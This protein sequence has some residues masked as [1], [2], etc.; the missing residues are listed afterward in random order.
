MKRRDALVS[1][2]LLPLT[3]S[4]WKNAE[5][6]SSSIPDNLK[7]L[8]QGD[9]I[10]DA[11]RN[12][13]RYYANDGYGMGNGYVSFTVKHLLGTQPQKNIKCYNRG[14]S[15]HKVHQ[16]A[17]RWDDDCLNL[18]P[19]VM[20]ILIGVNDY[21]HTLTHGYTGDINRYKNDYGV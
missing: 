20:S 1:T 18:K 17:D 12:R 3:I 2:G 7:I 6:L 9:S 14:I 15:G 11:G 19:D 8:F 5:I 4:L 10:T 21:W 16:L 13:G